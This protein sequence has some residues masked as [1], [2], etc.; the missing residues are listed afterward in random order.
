MVHY[1]RKGRPIRFRRGRP[2]VWYRKKWRGFR[3]RKTYVKMRLRYGGKWRL[4]KKRRR[5]WT[6]RYRGKIRRVTLRGRRFGIRIGGRWKYLPSRGGALQ[7]RYGRMWRRVRNCCNKLRAVLRGRLR[8]I[9]LRYGKATMRGKKGW[10][11]LL[12]KAVRR[13]NFRKVR[14]MWQ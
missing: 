9:R 6:I 7:I 13:F 4:V 14:G 3:R 1:G 8:R 11:K 2:L 10:T 12:R 5:R